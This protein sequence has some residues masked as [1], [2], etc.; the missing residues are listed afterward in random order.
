MYKNAVLTLKIRKNRKWMMQEI[1]G[2]ITITSLTIQKDTGPGRE[3]A[4]TTT[5]D[6]IEEFWRPIWENLRDKVHQDDW[7]R[8]I[9]T[10][11]KQNIEQPSEES[12][13]VT[14]EMIFESLKKR[15]NWSS[16]GKDNITNFWIKKRKVFHQD[17]TKALYLIIAKRLDISSWLTL[18]RSVMILKKDKPSASDYRPITWDFARR[19]L[20]CKTIY[21]LH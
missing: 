3:N 5:K 12:I 11:L 16:L 14:K 20:L 9:E 21:S 18:G 8:S 1:K 4:T 10:A 13:Q 19:L 15:R 17:I 6:E 7:I 2:N